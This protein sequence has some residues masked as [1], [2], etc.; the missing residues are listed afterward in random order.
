MEGHW[1]TSGCCS[2]SHVHNMY[3]KPECPEER[4]RMVIDLPYIS[5]QFLRF[6]LHKFGEIFI[7]MA[8]K[9]QTMDRSVSV[10]HIPTVVVI[11]DKIQCLIPFAFSM[12]HSRAWFREERKRGDRNSHYCNLYVRHF[13]IISHLTL[14]AIPLDEKYCHYS[15]DEEPE[16]QKSESLLIWTIIIVNVP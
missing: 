12:F 7:I 14:L 13:I 2:M 6:L 11:S 8:G 1:V 10:Q 4:V 15:T 3:G 9:S 16:A 5:P